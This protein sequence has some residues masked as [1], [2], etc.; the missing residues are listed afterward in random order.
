MAFSGTY[1]PK[2]FRRDGG[3]SVTVKS[4]GILSVD[5]GVG[6][7]ANQIRVRTTTANVNAGA[8][9]L[10]ALPGYAYRIHD[11][12]MIAIG[13]AAGA[14]TTVDVL[15]TQAAGS[16]K[17]LAVAIAAL[18]QS[19]VVRAGASNA[20][21]LADGASFVACDANTAITISKTGASLTTA[22]NIDVLL[23][24]SIEAQ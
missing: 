20:T 4:G 5:A 8:T 13:G 2:I 15:G 24:Y 16:V 12:A 23:T 6:G 22:T 18:T 9:L 21:V 19:A 1:S 17:L 3:D 14:T 11:I 7:Y 10:A